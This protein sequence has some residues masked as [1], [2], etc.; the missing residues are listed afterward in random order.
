[1]R[2]GPYVMSIVVAAATLIHRENTETIILRIPWQ[3]SAA[4]SAAAAALLLLLLLLL[5]VV[6][7]GYVKLN[8]PTYKLVEKST[9]SMQKYVF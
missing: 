7:L 8:L 9:E 3:L 6:F 4:A 2:H 5:V 1:M